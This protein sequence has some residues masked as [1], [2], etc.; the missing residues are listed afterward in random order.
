MPTKSDMVI[1]RDGD[2]TIKKFQLF[3][4]LVIWKVKKNLGG[5]SWFCGILTSERSLVEIPTI[6][7]APFIWIKAM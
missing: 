1:K 6:F 4:K 5:N 3:L 2:K 7:H